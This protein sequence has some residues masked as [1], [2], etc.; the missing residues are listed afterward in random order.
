MDLR[1]AARRV[2]ADLL[3]AELRALESEVRAG[4]EQLWS[5]RWLLGPRNRRPD[6]EDAPG[7][8]RSFCGC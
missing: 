1:G 8:L 2:V 6:F 7:R 4:A 3:T 5:A